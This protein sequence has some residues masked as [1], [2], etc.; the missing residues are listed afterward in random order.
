MTPLD[1]A[2]RCAL[3][4][5]DNA[6][7]CDAVCR[8][9]GGVTRTDAATWR[10]TA[11]SPQFYSNIITL[12]AGA[13]AVVADAVRELDPL[14]HGTWGI[15]DSFADLDLRPLGFE[16]LFEASWLWRS[17]DAAPPVDSDAEALRWERAATPGDLADWAQS[18]EPWLGDARTARADRTRFPATLLAHDD[19]AF[20]AGRRDGGIVAGGVLSA[21]AEVVGLCNF[22]GAPEAMDGCWRGL[23]REAAR[24]FPRRPLCGYDRPPGLAHALAQGFAVTGPLRVWLRARGG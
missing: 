13:Q 17:A 10:N 5:A 3:A 24:L 20:C 14:L 21:H 7:W 19:I 16:P 18:W 15:K 4:A 22:F 9:H 8:A 2:A 6:R 23:V 1:D 12:R 11:P